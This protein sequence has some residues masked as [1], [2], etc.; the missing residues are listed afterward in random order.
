MV[1]VH[2]SDQCPINNSL[3]RS[4]TKSFHLF[5]ATFRCLFPDYKQ[6]S[7]HRARAGLFQESSCSYIISV[8]IKR[9]R[10]QTHL[11][12]SSVKQAFPLVQA[13]Q[14]HTLLMHLLAQV[15]ST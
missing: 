3:S 10:S 5:R 1:S 11:S 13:T 4:Q 7:Q 14:V 12:Q 6:V 15:L 8:M 9:L 2:M